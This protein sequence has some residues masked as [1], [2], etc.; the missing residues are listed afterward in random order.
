M[1]SV[2]ILLSLFC[3]C[4]RFRDSNRVRMDTVVIISVG[5]FCEFVVSVSH[6]YE[7]L[8]TTVLL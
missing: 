4:I 3:V 2:Y 5:S 7:Y 8:L 6:S 1:T